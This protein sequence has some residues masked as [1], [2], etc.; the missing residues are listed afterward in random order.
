MIAGYHFHINV[1]P[2]EQEVGERVAQHLLEAGVAVDAEHLRP[3]CYALHIAGTKWFAYSSGGFRFDMTAEV[4]DVY[5][6]TNL[7]MLGQSNW[8]AAEFNF[9]FR[10]TRKLSPLDIYA[11]SAGLT[12]RYN[13]L[14]IAGTQSDD[15][16][17]HIP[18]LVLATF[19]LHAALGELEAML[20]GKFYRE[21]PGYRA[22]GIPWAGPDS[23]VTC[24]GWSACE[25]RSKIVAISIAIEAIQ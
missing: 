2:S 17:P 6:R 10:D 19:D 7:A 15:G 12:F 11:Q 1:R 25:I 13:G 21:R 24:Q 5:P 22:R 20:T 16:P 23:E 4:N 14:S 18:P 3:A 8:S 9:S